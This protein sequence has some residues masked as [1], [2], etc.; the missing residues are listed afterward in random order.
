MKPETIKKIEQEYS[1]LSS[2]ELMLIISTWLLTLTKH[3]QDYVDSQREIINLSEV[4]PVVKEILEDIL[5]KVNI[6]SK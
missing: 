1:R 6:E 3:T 5:D 2:I 4:R